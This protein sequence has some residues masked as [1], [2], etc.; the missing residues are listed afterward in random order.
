MARK[1]DRIDTDR[2]RVLRGEL[3]KVR[4]WLS[5]FAVGRSS[6]GELDL[7]IPGEDGLRQAILLIDEVLRERQK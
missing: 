7:G 6:R 3:T 2:L 4:C 1:R 5:G